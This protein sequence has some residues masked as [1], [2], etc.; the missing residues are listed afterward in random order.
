MLDISEPSHKAG[1]DAR[2][3]RRVCTPHIVSIED[4]IIV[5][6]GTAWRRSMP[7][8]DCVDRMTTSHM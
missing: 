8:F 1:V 4:E 5:L 7:M 2:C 6:P 3:E